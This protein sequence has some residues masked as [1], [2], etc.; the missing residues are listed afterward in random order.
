M[1]NTNWFPY[2]IKNVNEQDRIVVIIQKER[3]GEQEWQ[4]DAELY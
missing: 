2:C 3:E 1:R 4:K